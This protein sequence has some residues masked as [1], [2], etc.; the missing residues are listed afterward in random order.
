[1]IADIVEATDEQELIPTAL[2]ASLPV[3]P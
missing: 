3:A 2:S 1:V